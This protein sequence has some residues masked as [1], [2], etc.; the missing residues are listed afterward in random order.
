MQENATRL[1]AYRSSL[2]VFPR[3]S[4]KP[5]Q[6]DASKEEIA[7][8]SQKHGTLL[9][10]QPAE[11]KQLETITL[12]DDMKVHAPSAAWS[13]CVLSTRHVSH[14]IVHHRFHGVCCSAIILAV[15]LLS[16]KRASSSC[17]HWCLADC[18]PHVCLL[19][20]FSAYRQ[21]RQERTNKRLAGKRAKRAA[22]AAAE[23]KDKAK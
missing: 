14:M 17:V 15:W 21:L 22:E 12:T 4:G 8:A 19:Q 10:V 3:R 5:K 16:S 11:M 13:Q 23:E 18:S 2:I 7:S 1:K 20:A 6:G 9:P